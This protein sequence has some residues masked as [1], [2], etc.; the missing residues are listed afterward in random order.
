MASNE[1]EKLYTQLKR[2]Q[3]EIH[4][5]VFCATTGATLWHPP[6]NLLKGAG[7]L[8]VC[9][10]I[11]GIKREELS[12]RAE[13]KRLLIR[14]FRRFPEPKDILPEEGWGIYAM[15]IDYGQFE[16]IIDL[17]EEIE[18]ENVKAEYR[19]GMLWVIMPIAK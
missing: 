1:L 2:L 13:N 16:R 9:M 12:V 11:S 8:V 4:S 7:K 10:D 3:Y 18:P 19:D 5:T 6:V 17:P 14:G 15:E